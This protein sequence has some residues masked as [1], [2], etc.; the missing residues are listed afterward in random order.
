MRRYCIDCKLVVEVGEGEHAIANC[1]SCGGF[2]DSAPEEPALRKR[3]RPYVSRIALV[4]ADKLDQLEQHTRNLEFEAEARL[5][6]ER[7]APHSACT[8]K[9]CTALRCNKEL[10]NRCVHL[11]ANLT[12]EAAQRSALE[13]L[14]AQARQQGG[15]T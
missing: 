15:S 4:D 14:L 1:P 6:H 3:P 5:R 7:E 2:L 13:H 10:D 12:N 11:E 9:L 8:C